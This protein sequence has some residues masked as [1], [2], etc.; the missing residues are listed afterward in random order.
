[1]AL[2]NS[3]SKLDSLINHCKYLTCIR[4]IDSTLQNELKH[5][6]K[7]LIQIYL[8]RHAKPDIKKQKFYSRKQAEKYIYDYNHVPI[9]KFDSSLISINLEKEHTIYCSALRRSIETAHAIFKDNYP[10]ISDSIFN[11]FENKIIKSPGFVRQPLICWQIL[12][13]GTWVLGRK[14]SEI[15]SH[16]EAKERALLAASKLTDIAH[17]E[18]TAILIAHG[19]LNRAIAKKLK[20]KG[21]RAIQENGQKNLGATILIKMVDLN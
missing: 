14:P 19:M 1:M 6:N 8:I 3:V 12:S 17:K 13:R 9:Q 5:K 2:Q 7:K 18:E 20:Q 10:I 21:W 11:E 16:K 15:E 4:D